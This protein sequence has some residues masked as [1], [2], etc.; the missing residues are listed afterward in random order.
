MRIEVRSMGKADKFVDDDHLLCPWCGKK[1]G[2]RKLAM[3]F[4]Q[5]VVHKSPCYV[6]YSVA[7]NLPRKF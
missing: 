5:I 3:A 2:T 7:N 6:E 4:D 1:Y